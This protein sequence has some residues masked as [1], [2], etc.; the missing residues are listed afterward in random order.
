MDGSFVRVMKIRL[1]ENLASTW[2]P[3]GSFA[4]AWLV[5][6]NVVQAND[7]G[8]GDPGPV[9]VEISRIGDASHFEFS[10]LTQWKYEIKTAGPHQERV[11]VQLPRLSNQAVA[12]L[13]AL[14]S[15]WVRNIAV[16]QGD[17]D[18]TMRITFDLV[19]GTDFFDYISDEP[20]QLVLDLFPKD[21]NTE[22]GGA[23]A[24]S[25]AQS[26]SGAEKQ[27]VAVSPPR[28]PMR[29]SPG[30]LPA[31][32][33]SNR[34]PAG[35]EYITVREGRL[36]EAQT[37]AEKISSERGF[38]HGIFDGGD[39]EFRRFTIKDYEVNDAAIE[40]SR[41]NYYLPFPMLELGSPHLRALL[42]AP[43]TY[44]IVENQTDENKQ[45][46]LLLGFYAKKR[47]AILLRTAEQFL[48]KYPESPYEE[49]IRYL[50][51]DTHYNLW[52]TQGTAPDF[53][54][55][56]GQYRYLTE[57]FPESPATPRTLLLLGY[58]YVDR[59]DSFAALQSFQRFARLK[60]RSKHLDQVHIATADAFLKLNRYEDALQI[61]ERVAKSGTTERVRQEAAYRKGDVFF[62][63]K[64]YADAIASYQA[65]INEHPQA[66][67][68]FPNAWYNSAEAAFIQNRYRD[69][70]EA[71]RLF[72]TK[73]P[74]HDHGGY[75]MT[76]MGELIE[77]LTGDAKRAAGAFFESHFRYRSTPGAGIARIR[78]L[79]ARMPE[80]KEKELAA[81]LDEIALITNRYSV[82]EGSKRK[83]KERLSGQR[84]GPTAGVV[85]AATDEAGAGFDAVDVVD[86][87]DVD[88]DVV[89]V[90]GKGERKP[91]FVGQDGGPAM[92]D[93]SRRYED[94]EEVAKDPEL[95]GIEDFSALLVADGFTLRKE[96]DRSA[97]DL[98]AY[99]R[100]NPQSPVIDRIKSR[101]ERNLAAGIRTEVDNGNFIE[102]LRR[103][104]RDA[105]GWLKNSDR[106]DIKSDVGRA[107]EQAGV[108]T[109]AESIYSETLKKL[110]AQTKRKNTAADGV[111][112]TSPREE[113]I[114][115][116]LAAV[117]A[118]QKKFAEA[119]DY[120]KRIEE[121]APLDETEQVERAEISVD[122]AEARGQGD[123]ARR[124]LAELIKGWGGDPALTGPLHLRIA[125]LQHEAKDFAE[126]D[127][128]LLRVIDMHRESGLSPDV[129]ARALELR[130]DVLLAQGKRG[131][132]VRQYR[133]LLDAYESERPLDSIRYRMGQILFEDGDL[134]G[135]EA[136]WNGLK[137]GEDGNVWRQLAAEQMEGSKWRHDYKKYLNRIPA[138]AELRSQNSAE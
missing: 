134:K 128:H 106:L 79:S 28:R 19:K 96:F 95:P 110:T 69:S 127:Q 102:A 77:I 89:D 12:R 47:R 62:K 66:A 136:A 101:I 129:H 80:M 25:S 74:S 105:D 33:R 73:F 54:A 55:A 63:K 14:D 92:A 125:R 117:S 16:E 8:R 20:S 32:K 4:L 67:S 103:Y 24:A 21:G 137:T 22:S 31:K 30:E 40:A 108:Y 98:I 41:S 48:K 10:G 49:I 35:V 57:K 75:A 34:D 135:A 29:R 88:L 58:A 65:A 124:Y 64:N 118:K 119:E 81:A 11:T 120:L 71:Y 94:F 123:L 7:A 37:K 52:R 43:P 111:R 85:R 13:K 112:A 59:G 1:I 82:L 76:R 130:G 18:G 122:V 60:P 97:Q 109:E 91:A 70:L 26:G 36:P 23:V 5:A 6:G 38:S 27:T 83:A 86:V 3:L 131:E 42:K 84:R 39:P 17:L 72:L 90:D 121:D 100:K 113:S 51:A 9:E 99:Y 87:V 93:E 68:R 15:P 78:T 107:Y 114:L 44:E 56:M 138:A 46:R 61:L 115:L 2:K 126:A 133:E 116:R 132:A 53:E 50:M 45:A 104:G